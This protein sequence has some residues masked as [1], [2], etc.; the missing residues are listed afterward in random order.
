MQYCCQLESFFD[1]AMKNLSSL[2]IL[3]NSYCKKLKSLPNS[4]S[5]LQSLQVLVIN[6]CLKLNHVSIDPKCLNSLE[7]IAIS[8]CPSIKNWS[9]GVISKNHVSVESI[10]IPTTQ[11]EREHCGMK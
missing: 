9:E 2:Q 10:R 11:I 7:S 6:S 4:M 5:C 8:Y 3:E 1:A